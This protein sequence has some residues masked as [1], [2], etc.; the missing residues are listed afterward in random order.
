[1][2]GPRLGSEDEGR[3]VPWLSGY[4]IDLVWDNGV[5]VAMAACGMMTRI[6]QRPGLVGSPLQSRSA[7]RR[8]CMRAARP[9]VVAT[10]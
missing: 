9:A 7:A 10:S 3:L 4:R 6:A 1:M 5:S 8:V 2:Q